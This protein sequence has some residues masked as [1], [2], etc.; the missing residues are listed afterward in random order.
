M[1][2][3]VLPPDMALLS[4]LQNREDF[5][6]YFRRLTLDPNTVQKE[7]SSR[8]TTYSG[9][10]SPVVYQPGVNHTGGQG[11]SQVLPHHERNGGAFNGILHS[12]VAGIE[13]QGEVLIPVT[14]LLVQQP[15]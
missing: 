9:E 15:G 3:I 2:S 14:L 10:G 4:K 5:L 1:H 6:K 8:S 7:N 12:C 11:G 13:Q